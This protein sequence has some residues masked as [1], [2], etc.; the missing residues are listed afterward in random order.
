MGVWHSRR[1]AD[2]PPPELDGACHYGDMLQSDRIALSD[3]AAVDLGL[4]T[5]GGVRCTPVVSEW[6]T[7]ERLAHGGV[8]QESQRFRI[9]GVSGQSGVRARG[10]LASR[11]G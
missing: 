7:F 6:V 2:P 8:V 11:P 4:A 9:A 5:Q 10:A 3:Q 1:S